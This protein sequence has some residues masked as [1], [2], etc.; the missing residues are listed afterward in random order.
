MYYHM[1]IELAILYPSHT[2]TNVCVSVKRLVVACQGF[3]FQGFLAASRSNISFSTPE[4]PSARNSCSSSASAVAVATSL[5]LLS[6]SS[7]SSS[8]RSWTVPHHLQSADPDV[9][10]VGLRFVQR[11]FGLCVVCFGIT[12][13][14]THVCV[15]VLAACGGAARR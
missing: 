15:T 11:T 5:V 9:Y 4:P 13:C 14:V 8:K 2:C 7:A 6:A 12:V 3:S 1:T 10:A